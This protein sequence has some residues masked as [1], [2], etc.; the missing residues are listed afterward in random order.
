M[1]ATKSLSLFVKETVARLKGDDAEV[2]AIKNQR[3]ADSA[4]NGQLAALKA[5]LVD[6]ESAVED[7]EELL[8]NAIYP[9]TAITDNQAYV[10]GISK[11]HE[12]LEEAK[13]TLE[14]T[15]NSIAYFENIIKTKFN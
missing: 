12:A 3:K 8:N 7:G 4:I 2:L 14:N 1:E 15:K 11:A 5:K 6:D 10:R 13:E 9:N